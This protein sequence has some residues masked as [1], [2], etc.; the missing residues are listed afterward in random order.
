[1]AARQCQGYSGC[2]WLGPAAALELGRNKFPRR[3]HQ[4]PAQAH[5][6]ASAGTRQH[7]ATTSTAALQQVT[8]STAALTL[9]LV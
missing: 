9:S 4:Q 1:M 7:L 6:A 5:T 8:S 3:Q 2:C